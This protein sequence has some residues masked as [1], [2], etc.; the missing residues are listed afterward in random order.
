MWSTGEERIIC[1]GADDILWLAERPYLAPGTLQEILVRT[2]QERAIADNRIVS[3]LR[4]LNL[5][6][7]LARVGGLD[8]EQDWDTVLSLSEHKLLAF[9]HILLAVPRFAFLARP[10]TA[11]SRDQVNQ[12]LKLLSDNSISYLT[13]GETSDPLEFYD[14][15]LE[16]TEDGGWTWRKVRD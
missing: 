16:I 11:L 1:P 3:M 14:G 15:V 2:G 7:V 4:G 13:I 9:I 10:G 8:R 12:I 6:P 5:E